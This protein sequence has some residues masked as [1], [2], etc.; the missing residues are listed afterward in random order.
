MDS[1]FE[2]RITGQGCLP[3]EVVVKNR[4]GAIMKRTALALIAA[5]IVGVTALASPSPAEARW[6]GGC[7]PGI[8]GGL[9]GAAGIGGLASITGEQA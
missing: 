8:A 1:R 6:R 3:V 9:I 5:G 2:A 7:G 4:K